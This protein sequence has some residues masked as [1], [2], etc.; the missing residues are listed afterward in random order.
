MREVFSTKIEHEIQASNQVHLSTS[1]T[2]EIA[3]VSINDNRYPLL[4]R[5]TSHILSEVNKLEGSLDL[6][7]LRRKIVEALVLM[8]TSCFIPLPEKTEVIASSFV[9]IEDF[10]T[11]CESSVKACWY[12]M[13][14]S[15]L[16]TVEE[17]LSISIPVLTRLLNN[18]LSISKWQQ[19]LEHKLI[20]SKAA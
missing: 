7:R 2:E 4:F 15:R 20:S 9:S 17:I 1:A 5:A 11:Q 14:G 13:K 12:L 16:N 6:D 3:I 8:S 19:E 18:K 10:L